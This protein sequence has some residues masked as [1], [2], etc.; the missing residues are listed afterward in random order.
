[1]SGE[2][3]R[4]LRTRIFTRNRSIIITSLIVE[5]AEREYK[6]MHSGCAR[7]DMSQNKKARDFVK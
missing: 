3:N 6:D 7:R 4:K 1:M 2:I 5:I